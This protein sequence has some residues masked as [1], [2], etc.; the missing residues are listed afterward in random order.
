V[1]ISFDTLVVI[2]CGAEGGEDLAAEGEGSVGFFLVDLY[3]VEGSFV[4]RM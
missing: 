1:T 4:G 2:I 3:D